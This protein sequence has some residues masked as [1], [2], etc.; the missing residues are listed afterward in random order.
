M[1]PISGSA[2]IARLAH[3]GLQALKMRYDGIACPNFFYIVAWTSISVSTP[4]PTLAHSSVMRCE[5]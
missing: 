2:A 4:K 5:R 3:C 1:G